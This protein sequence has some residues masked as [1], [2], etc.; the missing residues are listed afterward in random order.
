MEFRIL[1]PLEVWD[2]SRPVSLSGPA[3]SA[4]MPLLLRAESRS[5]TTVCSM[6]SGA[7]EPAASPRCVASPAR[8]LG[9]T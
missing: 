3:A 5:R 1:G 4:L 6:G 9:R 8:A 2:G 7:T